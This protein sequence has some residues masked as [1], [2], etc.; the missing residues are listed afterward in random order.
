MSLSSHIVRAAAIAVFALT[1]ITGAHAQAPK[2]F[3][4][5]EAAAAALVEA[6]RKKDAEGVVAVLGPATREWII[7]GDAVQDEQGRANFIAA[8]D[9]RHAIEKKGDTAILVIGEDG[10]PFALPIVKNAKGWAFDPA[11]GKEEL[12]DRRIGENELTTIQVML[13]IADAQQDYAAGDPDGDGLREYAGRFA[14]SEGKKDGL[15]WPTAEGEPQSPLGPLVAEAAREGY[16]PSPDAKADETGAYHGYRFRI[17]TAQGKNAPGGAYDYEA[18]GKLIGGF[19]ILAY[20]A[21][22]GASGIMSFMTSHD[23]KVYEGDLGP[24]TEQEAHAIKEF[25]P[26]EGWQVVEVE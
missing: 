12:L 17:L 16:K 15:F 11:K 9:K 10:F 26:G 2:A 6:A 25:D 14:S 18:G 7:S 21:R 5:P 13:A 23:G 20:P 8:Y 24:D 22:Y 3:E 1:S 4:T 19:A